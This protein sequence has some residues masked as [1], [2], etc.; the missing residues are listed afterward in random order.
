MQMED[1]V[2]I[3]ETKLLESGAKEVAST[4]IGEL[5][6]ERLHEICDYLCVCLLWVI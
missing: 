1:I 6:I 4:D 2:R 3:I 5:V